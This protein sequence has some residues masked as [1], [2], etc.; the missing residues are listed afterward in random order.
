[1]NVWLMAENMAATLPRLGPLRFSETARSGPVRDEAVGGAEREGLRPVPRRRHPH[2][3]PERP[4]ERAQAREP[5][6]EA[7]LRDAAIR[8]AQQEH[9]PF[10]PSPLQVA[11]R[12]LAE[13][14]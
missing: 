8:L 12:R 3:P 10:H 1:M 5:D 4:A 11:V 7:D 14:L 2:D 13:R 9:R 6:V